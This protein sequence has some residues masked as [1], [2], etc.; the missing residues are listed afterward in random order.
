MVP[1]ARVLA[2]G[3]YI[4]N[5]VTTLSPLSSCTR[6]KFCY[7]NDIY[8]ILSTRCTSAKQQLSS[9]HVGS[10]E[11]CM[12]WMTSSGMAGWWDSAQWVPR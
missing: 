10:L 1:V 8:L 6:Y 11:P 5:T 3:I 7:I 12:M 4:F 2:T 9:N